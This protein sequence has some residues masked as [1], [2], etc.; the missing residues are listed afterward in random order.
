MANYK[1]TSEKIH[2]Q[3]QEVPGHEHEMDPRP[4]YIRENYRGSG[5]LEGKVALITGGDSGIGRAVAV[6]FA[7]EGADIAFVYLEEDRDAEETRELVE[8]E[9]R[10]CLVFRGDIRDREF[11]RE[12]VEKTYGHFSKLNIL[13][14]HAGEQHPTTEPQELDLDLMEKTFHTNIFAMYYL[15]LPA[16]E[17]MQ[18]DDCIINTSSVT[19]YHGSPRFLDYSAT[20]GAIV[21]FTRALANNLAKR[22]IRVN[23]VAPGPI[24]TPLIT[25]TFEGEDVEKFGMNTPLKR[26]GQPCEVAPSYVLL[27]SEDGS[28]MTGQVLHPNGGMGMYS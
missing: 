15:T 16:L 25:S 21:S 23:G 2:A 27:A 4:V 20:N 14:N 12:V 5:K 1:E 19:A 22:K 3:K 18:E 10:E 24:W 26:P 11:C 9:G 8:N 6:H 13:V 17:Y 7:R 28:Y